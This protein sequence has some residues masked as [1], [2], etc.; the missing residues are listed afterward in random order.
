MRPPVLRLVEQIDIAERELV[1]ALGA[2]YRGGERIRFRLR[3]GVPLSEAEVL[4]VDEVA[5]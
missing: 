5:A 1:L 2:E 4:G 3:D